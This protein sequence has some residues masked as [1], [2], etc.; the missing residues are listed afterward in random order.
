MNKRFKYVVQET[1]V[2]ITNFVTTLLF[3]NEYL[4]LEQLHL[5][6]IQHKNVRLTDTIGQFATTWDQKTDKL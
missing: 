1:A 2:S 4:K 6:Y 5:S 3:N